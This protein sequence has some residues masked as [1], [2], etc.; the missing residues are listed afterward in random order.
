VFIYNVIDDTDQSRTSM[1]NSYTTCYR[2]ALIKR[3]HFTF[4][5]ALNSVIFNN[6]KQAKTGSRLQKK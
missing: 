3:H 4:R 1:A 6:K 2:V 5:T